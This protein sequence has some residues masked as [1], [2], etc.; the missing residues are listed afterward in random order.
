MRINTPKHPLKSQNQPEQGQH[1]P[2][3]VLVALHPSE[4]EAAHPIGTRGRKPIGGFILALAGF[5]IGIILVVV[6]LG[7]GPLYRWARDRILETSPLAVAEQLAQTGQERVSDA[8]AQ[9]ESNGV[10]RSSLSKEQRSAAPSDD[11]PPINIL[12]MGTDAR[13]EDTKPA[14][15]DTMMLLSLTPRD[16][17]VGILSLPRDL[18]VPIP[19]QNMTSKINM[20]YVIGENG[21]YPGGGAYLAMDTVSSFIGRPV[22]YYIRVNFSGF[23]QFIDLIGGIDITVPHTIHDQAYPTAD[24]G[25][26]LFHLEPGPQHL[27]GEVALKYVRTRNNDDDY[28]RARRQQQVIRAIANKV[29][30]AN[31]ISALLPKL[32]TLFYTM[33]SSIDTNIPMAKQLELAQY[34]GNASVNN[35]RQLVL[36]NRYGQETYTEEGAWILLPNREMVSVALNRFFAPVANNATDLHQ[37]ENQAAWVRVEVLNGTGQPRIAART[38]ELLEARGWQVVSIDD[39]DRNDYQQTLIIDYGV[40]ESLVDQIGSDLHL[41]S[42]PSRLSMANINASGTAPVDL[43]IVVGRDYLDKLTPDE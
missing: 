3:E 10:E 18:W 38:R 11:L 19:G 30:S 21:N 39:A 4:E 34:A 12:L 29:L 35:I 37:N 13:P 9:P 40:P 22:D 26:E 15:T 6:I 1:R 36:D 42:E 8:G 24:Y 17:T 14:R 43:R 7:S 32:P 25:V 31:M 28:G 5:Y 2:A 41:S 27:S 23:V 33:R 20:A 16:Q